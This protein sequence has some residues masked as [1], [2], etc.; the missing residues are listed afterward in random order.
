VNEDLKAVCEALETI[1]TAV[2][3]AWGSDATLCEGIGWNAPAVTRHDLAAIAR[4]LAKDIE[5]TDAASPDEELLKIIKDIPRRLTVVRTNT[6]PQM[7]TGNAGQAIPAYIATLASIRAIVLPGIGWQSIPDAKALPSAVAKRARAAEAELNQLEPRI[8]QVS[9][10]INEIEAA[11]KIADSLPI[12]LQAL[13]EARGKLAAAATDAETSGAKIKS[14]W[15]ESHDYRDW[16][17]NH[18]DEAGKLI[19][20]C[21]AAYQITTTKGLAGAFDQ[22]ATTLSYS[23]YGWVAG[24]VIALVLGSLIGAERLLQLSAALNAA[25]PNWGSIAT[26]A[27]LSV[28]S[29]GAPLW[30]AWLAT[31]QI[32]QRFRLSE[33]YAFKA[34]VAK[35]YEG[36]RKEAAR[37]DPEFEARLFGSALTRLEEAPLRLVEANSHGSPWHE[38]AN[39]A[40]VQRAFSLA[41][42]LQAKVESLIRESVAATGRTLAGTKKS[43]ESV[44]PKV[45]E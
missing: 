2:T 35:A 31:K 24:L 34:S 39:S 40:A 19:E 38:L 5:S 7:F 27:L 14:L 44:N 30:F 1:A 33:D 13:G 11:H 37:I 8:K 3:N 43:V 9:K 42:E 21:E 25:N 20:K 18:H 12:D 17:K 32:G 22:R 29:V 26:Q 6:L 15:S 28:L 36:Y 16:M 10:Q 4:Q 23:M 45:N 41:P